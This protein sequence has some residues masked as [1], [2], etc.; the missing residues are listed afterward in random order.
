VFDQKALDLA[1]ADR[2]I[3]PAG[4]ALFLAEPARGTKRSA[5]PAQNIILFDGSYRACDIF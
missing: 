2:T 3:D 4:A 1:N 5:C